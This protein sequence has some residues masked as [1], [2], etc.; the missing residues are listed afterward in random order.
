LLLKILAPVSFIIFL[1]ERHPIVDHL[2][3]IVEV[4]HANLRL[5]V[6]NHHWKIPLEKK[7]K[8]DY[9]QFKIILLNIR[10]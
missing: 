2:E 4:L 9:N 6:D 3:H 8:E 5:N 10:E 7:K 1:L